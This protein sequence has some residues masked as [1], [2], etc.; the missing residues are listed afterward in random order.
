MIRPDPET[1]DLYVAV[2]NDKNGY[3]SFFRDSVKGVDNTQH[4]RVT[5][6]IGSINAAF[7]LQGAIDAS[8]M[9]QNMSF[10]DVL[11]NA[12]LCAEHFLAVVPAS[13]EFPRGPDGTGR[14]F[15][16][17]WHKVDEFAELDWA[18][19]RWNFI[20]QIRVV[21]NC[22]ELQ[23]KAKLAGVGDLSTVMAAHALSD[24][25][26]MITTDAERLDLLFGVTVRTL[27]FYHSAE[28][29]AKWFDENKVNWLLDDT[30]NKAVQITEV[31]KLAAQFSTCDA[32]ISS[33]PLDESF[34]SN[35]AAQI[36]FCEL[37]H[38]RVFGAP[39]YKFS[40]CNWALLAGR[41]AGAV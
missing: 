16:T 1:G 26:R 32:F 29:N 31:V 37:E 35:A 27:R 13:F 18:H 8:H 28:E 33:S 17:H 19:F 14:V 25:A 12:E 41:L 7:K 9:M 4:A 6:I 20:K 22:I 24:K 36:S 21:L 10:S 2:H 3:P 30:H 40:A 39:S 15:D 5:K 23:Y 34:Y 11:K 38:Q